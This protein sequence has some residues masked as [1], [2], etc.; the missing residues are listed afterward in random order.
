MNEGVCEVLI[1]VGLNHQQTQSIVYLIL[2]ILKNIIANHKFSKSLPGSL[3]TTLRTR[4][5]STS[6]GGSNHGRAMNGK[7]GN[8][9]ISS[10]SLKQDAVM[11]QV[12][13]EHRGSKDMTGYDAAWN[14]FAE[15]IR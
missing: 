9:I 10:S 3:H 13:Q 8:K 11:T 15:V 5:I 4:A 14:I 1:Q 12:D 6:S 2:H 7:L